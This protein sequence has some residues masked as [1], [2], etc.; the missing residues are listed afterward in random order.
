MIICKTPLRVSFLGGGTDYP[1]YFE[2]HGGSVLATAIDK[3]TYVNATQLTDFFQHKIRLSYSKTELVENYEEIQ[4]RVVKEA[5]KLLDIKSHIELNYIADLPAR[6]GLGSSSSFAVCLL[7]ALYT[8]KGQV[9]S[10]ETLAKEA[11][12]LEIDI[13]KDN[14]GCQDQTMAAI[15]G[16]Q[17]VEFLPGRSVRYTPIIINR[18]RLKE[19]N[20]NLLLFFTGIERFASEVASDQIKRTQINVPYLND[21]KSLTLEGKKVIEGTESL[22]VFGKLLHHGWELKRSLSNKISNSIIDEIY[23]V[24]LKAGAT[25]GKLLGAGNGGFMLFYVEPQF[26]E[27]VREALKVLKEVKFDFEPFGSQIIYYKQ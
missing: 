23:E 11:I 10:N 24:G 17:Y 16:F 7:H 22:K 2:S 4:H 27:S 25:G 18:E 12:S 9:V 6:T 20:H 5:L 13:L 14:V 19:L 8:F 1:D 21:L 26:Q 3:Y 15:G